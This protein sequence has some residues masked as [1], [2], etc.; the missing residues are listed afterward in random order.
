VSR[1]NVDVRKVTEASAAQEYRGPVLQ[2]KIFGGR[3]MSVRAGRRLV[4]AASIVAA[5]VVLLLVACIA[6]CGGSSN[7]TATSRT[8]ASIPEPSGSSRL[9]AAFVARANAVCVRANVATEKAHGKFP[10][11]SFDPLHPDAKL[12]PRVGAFF[13]SS[14]AIA[15]RVPAELQALGDPQRNA[16]LWHQMLVLSRQS[17]GIAHR[18]V[19]AAQTSNALAFV[20]TVR[21]IESVDMN[22]GRMAITAGFAERSPCAHV[23]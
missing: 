7:S 9:D 17:R 23:F 14:Q 4:E 16:A 20:T 15:D 2:H 13:A 19:A 12:L 22:L 5:A 21:A 1:E 11:S 3:I 18:Q 10:Y 8:T 6:G